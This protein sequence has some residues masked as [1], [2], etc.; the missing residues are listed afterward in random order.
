[1]S[2]IE[3]RIEVVAIRLTG[4]TNVRSTEVVASTLEKYFREVRLSFLENEQDLEAVV[5]RRPDLV[6]V[7]LKQLPSTTG[8]PIDVVEYLERN[9]ITVSGSGPIAMEHERDKTKA[10]DLVLKAGLDS[11]PYFMAQK[12]QYTSETKLPIEFPLFIKPHNRGDGFGVDEASVVRN[13]N[14]FQQKIDQLAEEGVTDALVEK[15]FSG[16]EFTVAVLRDTATKDLMVMPIEQLPRENAHGDKIIGHAMKSAEQETSVGP[17]EQGK[18]RESVIKLARSTFE[19]VGARDYGRID[20]RLDDNEIPHF[21]E[22]NLIPNLVKGSGN[23]TKAFA[24]NTDETY[25]E[26]LLRIV[27][28]AFARSLVPAP[29]SDQ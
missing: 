12:G 4:H 17:L 16:R 2:K 11:S 1:M 7:G 24:M 19:T 15:Y 5:N 27:N 18:I 3:K 26:L 28:L 29:T 10:K 14:E 8:S 25:D 20:M 9:G 22:M 21:L 23:F 13:F 6:F